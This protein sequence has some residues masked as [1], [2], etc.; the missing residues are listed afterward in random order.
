VNEPELV[1]VP[2]SLIVASAPAL[3]V[4]ATLLTWTVAPVVV[5][6]LFLSMTLLATG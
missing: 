3:T 1:K 5:E 2:P 6:P 4:G